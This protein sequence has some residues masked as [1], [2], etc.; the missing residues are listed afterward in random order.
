VRPELIDLPEQLRGER[1]LLRPYR[2]G[3]GNAVFAALEA[4]REDLKTWLSWV[5]N[6][7]SLDD[8]EAYVRLMAGRWITREALILGIWSPAGEYCGGTGFHGFD[9][10]VP[11]FE[12]G[13]FLVP[14]KRG[15]GYASE[16]VRLLTTWARVNLSAR[17]VWA[18]CDATNERSW[19]VLERCG[20]RREAHLV[21][22]RVDHHGR[23]R[24]T[25]V[26]AVT[27]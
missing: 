14:G 6:H 10:R 23:L 25:F 21:H 9:W 5:D 2:A 13:Y 4:N 26:Y 18:S 24:D 3:D 8:S 27:A 15:H 22:E 16:A 11:S 17:R 7:R 19:K 1:V 20:F 12:L